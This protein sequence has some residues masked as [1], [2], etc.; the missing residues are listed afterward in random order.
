MT[1]PELI[2]IRCAVAC[3]DSNGIPSLYPCIVHVSRKA[4]DNDD[5]YDVAKKEAE[6]EGYES[7]DLVFD[8]KDHPQMMALFDWTKVGT[9]NEH[10]SLKDLPLPDVRAQY[11]RTVHEIAR[12][13]NNL[14][15]WDS[16]NDPDDDTVS[17][18]A[19][20]DGFPQ[21]L[22][23][24]GCNDEGFFTDEGVVQIKTS[25]MHPGD[26]LN[27]LESREGR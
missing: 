27:L 15:P 23:F 6:D 17:V 22:A 3:V 21:R 14:A 25:T 1:Q 13:V 20:L 7:C 19:D 2:H 24:Q 8:E 4:Y 26:L 11:D 12:R 16:T 9:K 18:L 10:E 5:H